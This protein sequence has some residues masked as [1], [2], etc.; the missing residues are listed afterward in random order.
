MPTG[1]SLK[2]SLHPSR[3]IVC[4]CMGLRLDVC[5]WERERFSP[6][7][8][9]TAA[10]QLMGRMRFCKCDEEEEKIGGNRERERKGDDEE[11]DM[12]LFWMCSLIYSYGCAVIVCLHACM[13]GRFPVSFYAAIRWNVRQKHRIKR[14][15]R[16][17]DW[18]KR[19]WER[20]S[21]EKSFSASAAA[22]SRTRP[23]PWTHSS[24]WDS[25]DGT[26]QP[27]YS[28]DKLYRTDGTQTPVCNVEPGDLLPAINRLNGK[29]THLHF[30]PNCSRRDVSVTNG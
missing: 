10:P 11:R 3:W 18:K 8:L 21:T 15:G 28:W 5:V 13:W 1:T 30:T 16:G 4:E 14:G 22:E 20:K 26:H 29:T 27:T 19:T 24:D 2:R 9:V 25:T 12:Q 17:E 23:P 7:P 6:Y